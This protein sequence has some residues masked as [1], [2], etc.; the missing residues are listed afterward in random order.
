RKWARA[1]HR[2]CSVPKTWWAYASSR[3]PASRRRSR[4]SLPAPSTPRARAR[5]RTSTCPATKARKATGRASAL[6]APSCQANEKPREKHHGAFV[7][8]FSQRALLRGLFAKSGFRL[9]GDFGE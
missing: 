1:K 9:L 3:K 2:R 8:G 5:A 7:I 6:K 4:P